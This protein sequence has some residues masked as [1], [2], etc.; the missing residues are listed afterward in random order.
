VGVTGWRDLLGQS[1]G[2]LVIPWLGTRRI[3][4]K[5]GRALRVVGRTPA[6]FGWYLWEVSGR[7]ATCSQAHEADHD[8]GE[9]L[10]KEQGY[11]VG[12]RYVRSFCAVNPDLD[13]MFEE[14]HPVFLIEPGLDRFTHVEIMLDLGGRIIY[15]QEL[16]PLG[17]EDEVRRA[18]IDRKESIGNIPNVTPAL[19]LAFRFATHQRQLLEERRAELERIREEERRR[20]EAARSMGTGLGRRNLAAQD[21]DTA[22]RAAL[23]VG[24]ADLLDVRYG[25]TRREAVVQF[26]LE[27]RRFECVA[28]RETL[29]IV[30]SGICLE[31]HHTHE[32]GDTYFTLES[33][34]GVIRQAIREG[35]LV[36]YRHVDDYDDWE[37]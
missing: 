36:V 37:D 11:L 29:R 3:F 13:K 27:G 21:F 24:N 19:D 18:F 1:S 16:F 32:K 5:D 26:R 9:S 30:D 7:T 8:Y 25:R 28:E 20:E 35:R 14:T 34:P 10:P 15:S 31:D 33:L 4:T 12:D 23:A 6:D 2:C 22:A 17:P